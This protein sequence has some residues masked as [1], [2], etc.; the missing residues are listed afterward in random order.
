M[1]FF[2]ITVTYTGELQFEKYLLFMHKKKFKKCIEIE[3]SKN[4]K[5]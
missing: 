5:Q 2:F 1:C 4:L 3:Y